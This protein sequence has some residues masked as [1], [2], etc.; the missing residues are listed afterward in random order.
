[1]KH[2]GLAIGVGIYVVAV[3]IL[4]VLFEKGY[5]N[6]WLPEKWQK[7]TA[8]PNGYKPAE[9]F[10]GSLAQPNGGASMRQCLVAGDSRSH[11]PY[12]NKCTYV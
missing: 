11:T 7:K 9:M 2:Q 6:R 3:I 10:F 1:M 12:F 8:H 5:L 4:V